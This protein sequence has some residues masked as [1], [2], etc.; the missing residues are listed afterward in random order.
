[1]KRTV[2]IDGSVIYTNFSQIMGHRKFEELLYEFINVLKIK[3]SPLLKSLNPFKIGEEIDVKRLVEYLHLLSMRKI[4]EITNIMNYINPK[5]LEKFIESFYSFWRNKH[6]FM[7]RQEKYADDYNRR[8][9]LEYTMTM[10]GDQFKAVIK[11]MYRQLISNT[12]NEFPTI[13]RQLPS[14]A[15]VMFLYDFIKCENFD[16]KWIEKIP[17]FGEAISNKFASP[18]PWAKYSLCTKF[19]S[20]KSPTKIGILNHSFGDNSILSKIELLFSKGIIPFLLLDFV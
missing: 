20:N 9:S 11:N 10:V 1:M 3:N 4:K 13:M 16:T 6:R 19:K 2:I 5:D 18:A 15:Q 7:I 12:T 8:T 17:T 14:G